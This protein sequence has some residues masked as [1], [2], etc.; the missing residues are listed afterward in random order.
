LPLN[1]KT[2]PMKKAHLRSLIFL[3][4]LSTINLANGQT[5]TSKIRE[6]KVGDKCPDFLFTHIINN[7][8][9]EARLSDFKGKLVILD[10]WA[11]WCKPCVEA[12]AKLD[13]IQNIFRD[14]LKILPVTYET[15]DNIR[16]FL[17]NNL[18]NK[19]NRLPF[20]TCDT[21][22]EQI[23]SH[24][25]IPHE[26]LID[27]NGFVKEIIG[28]T[29]VTKENIRK[30]ISGENVKIKQKHDIMVRD[31]SKP[32][33]LGYF[34]DHKL[35]SQVVQYSST[36]TSFID[37]APSAALFPINIGNRSTVGGLNLDI[38]ALYRICVSAA[39]SGHNSIINGWGAYKNSYLYF[40]TRT[41]WEAKDTSLYFGIDT[42]PQW[43]TSRPDSLIRFTYE[44][45]LPKVDST[46]LNEIM[47]QDLNRYFGMQFGIVGLIERR[48]IK[49]WAL[50]R[51]GDL[52]LIK[53]KGGDKD[54][55]A[56]DDTKQFTIRNALLSDFIFAWAMFKQGNFPTPIVNEI[57][58]PYPI[59]LQ[60]VADP[61]DFQSV[62][63]ALKKF[64]IEFKL[65]TRNLDMLV[66]KDIK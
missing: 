12:L 16:E 48:N 30:L 3:F 22:L 37:G 41:I 38:A 44:L 43:R 19:N 27:G 56:N 5:N 65:V 58:Y 61:E 50:T 47:L 26:I 13:T 54:I 14:S 10:F 45:I 46:K 32:L 21:V 17:A 51:I 11:T 55:Y 6:L 52:D 29:E 66:I 62:N 39:P 15:E 60:F 42:K 20:I 4:I 7:S 23:F 34:G 18:L 9:S 59:D 2:H 31:R 63:N 53:S 25:E 64:G 36:I 24:H 28:S 8:T 40:R 57:D 35:D 33:L 49:C 1:N